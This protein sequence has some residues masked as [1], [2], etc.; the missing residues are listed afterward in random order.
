MFKIKLYGQVKNKSPKNLFLIFLIFAFC[1][2][3]FNALI[4]RLKRKIRIDIVRF[5]KKKK[6]GGNEIISEIHLTPRRSLVSD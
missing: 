3:S 6:K 2:V 1:I 5:K 4:V